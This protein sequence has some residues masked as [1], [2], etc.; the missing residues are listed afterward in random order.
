M[1]AEQRVLVTRPAGQADG[2]IACLRD[3]GLAVTHLPMLVL[4]TIDPLPGADRQR[5]LDLDNYDDLI[6]ISANAAQYGVAAI[7]DYWPQF[8][9]RQQY[10][11]VGASTAA[12]LSA[13][14][15]TAQYPASNMSSEGLLALPGLQDP[16]ERRMLIIKGEGGR[17]ALRAALAGRGARVDTLSCYR[18]R[19]PDLDAAEYRDA[20]GDDPPQLLLVSS[21]EGLENLARLLS[22]GENT[23]VAHTTIIV[24][25]ARV[26]EQADALGW[27]DIRRAENASDAAVL[28]AVEAWLRDAG[29]ESFGENSSID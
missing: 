6:F 11:A 14:G 1:H 27:R 16:G 26:A 18:R 8:P 10:W 2:L 28:V 13:E 19:A 22:P 9:V 12:V 24:P 25:S 3:L 4:E 5:L 17:D 20:W 15:L 23:N 29:R 21:G 7:R